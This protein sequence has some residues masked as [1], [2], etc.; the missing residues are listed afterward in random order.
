MITDIFSK[1]Y[2]NSQNEEII[3]E[4]KFFINLYNLFIKDL[5]TT[6][7]DKVKDFPYTDCACE[8]TRIVCESMERVCNELGKLNLEKK[9]YEKGYFSFKTLETFQGFTFDEKIDTLEKISLFEVLFGNVEIHFQNEIEFLEKKIP[10]YREEA[11][12]INGLSKEE[13]VKYCNNDEEYLKRSEIQLED[14]RAKLN[15]VNKEINYRLKEYKKSLSYHNGFFQKATNVILEINIES[16]FWGL[17]SK[18]CYKNVEED[19]LEAIDLYDSNGRD[20]AF[21]AA[22]AL[23][24][25]LKIIC[26]KKGFEIGNDK[27]SNKYIEALNSKKN[28][29]LISNEE[30]EVLTKEF[31][32]RHTHGHGPG[33]DDMPNLNNTQKLRYIHSM[34]AWV[35]SLSER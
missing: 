10:E 16:P 3:I 2:K 26:E 5:R 4:N 15:L 7:M 30:K 35:Y 13:G 8:Q 20:P 6:L 1:R 12:R 9:E 21:Y 25:M 27:N 29:V 19:M 23:E 34:M 24:S 28:G 22:K 18:S 33:S 17:V 31:K 14:K 11:S 32:I